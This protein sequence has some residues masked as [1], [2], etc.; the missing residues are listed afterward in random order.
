MR[1]YNLFEAVRS[2]FRDL[3]RLL[4]SRKA[5]K[6][7]PAISFTI[8]PLSTPGADDCFSATAYQAWIEHFD[9]LTS[10]DCQLMR[11]QSSAGFPVPV[12]VIFLFDQGSASYANAAAKSLQQQLFD[13]WEG[14]LCFLPGCG[15]DV[16][17]F[18]QKIAA[19]DGRLKILRSPLSRA[20][21]RNVLSQACVVL[22]AGGVVLREHAVFMFASAALERDASVVYSDEDR[23]N[24]EGV[25]SN[26]FFKPRLSPELARNTGYIGPC[27][28]LRRPLQ[29]IVILVE[30]LLNG[31]RSVEACIEDT[32][33]NAANT[34][35]MRVPHVL[36][37][38]AKAERSSRIPPL[39]IAVADVSLPTVSVIIP[40]KDRL[41]LLAACLRSIT[42]RTDYPRTKWEVVVVDNCSSDAT[43]LSYLAELEESDRVR[44]LR[45]SSPF[46]YSKI[47]NLAVCSAHS[48]VLV[49]LN[50]DTVIDDSSW[51]RRLTCYAMQEGVGAVGPKLLYPDR[52]VQFGGTVLGISGAAGHAHVGLDE[53]AG[54]YHNFAN[55]TREVSAV[56]GACLAVRRKVFDEIGGF[57]GALATAFNDVLF[58]LE[59]SARGYRNIY[60]GSTKVFHLESRT[61][62]YDDTPEKIV[63]G[64]RE[65]QYM[66]S[67]HKAA[68][69]DDPYYNPNLSLRRPYGL[70]FPPRR[71]KPWRAAARSSGKLRILMLSAVH[72]ARHGFT[73]VLAGQASYLSGLG[74]DVFV[75][76]P[77]GK[78]ELTYDGC[79]RTKLQ[80]TDDAACF[81]VEHDIDCVMAH[82]ASFFSVVRYF[83]D[84]PKT[85]LYEY[86]QASPEYFHEVEI[87][88]NIAAEKKLCFDL[89][90]AVYAISYSVQA[91]AGIKRMGVIPL[92]NTP[93][94]VNTIGSNH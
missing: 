2:Y 76:G 84:W 77:Q 73:E 94:L 8:G 85:L 42:E 54:G 18:V 39:P 11:Q 22:V 66:R 91:K 26:P 78:N 81:A 4:L 13:G 60:L 9:Q 31:R 88:W 12:V 58:C 34:A 46:N 47:N 48:E 24:A 92:G 25:R 38:D 93:E 56:T 28:L 82:T 43:T 16:I 35:V 7:R 5:K 75:G 61:R 83:G 72:K 45:D 87:P 20:E 15:E 74:H 19:C 17:D 53:N 49:F 23:I 10:T 89:A 51:L 1:R 40:T 69:Q 14:W 67:K 6:T 63:M 52:T 50:N 27:A 29:E 68:I 3:I 62:G 37:H 21:L 55:T 33:R 36:Y 80:T 57:D 59:A 90:S 64:Q 30:D 32:A 65:A 44:V 71:T 79:V 41:D 86:G 70:A